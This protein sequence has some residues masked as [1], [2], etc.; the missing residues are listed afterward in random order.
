MDLI[1]KNTESQKKKKKLRKNFLRNQ[2][3]QLR[4]S[5]LFQS[6]KYS[7]DLVAKYLKAL[8]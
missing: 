7:V 4:Y 1:R 8:K 5:L 6:V 3:L 2:F